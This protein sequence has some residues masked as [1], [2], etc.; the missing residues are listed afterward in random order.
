MIQ[1]LLIVGT[2]NAAWHLGHAC[3][4]AGITIQGVVARDAM[5]GRALAEALGGVPYFAMYN[6]LPDA[7]AYLL[8]V[9]DDAIEEVAKQLGDARQLM[10]HCSGSMRADVLNQKQNPYGVLWPMHSLQ[11]D[12]PDSLQHALIAVQGSDT[13]IQQQ[14]F[15]LASRISERAMLVEEHQRMAMHMCAVWVN[16]YTNH[17]LHI[18]FSLLRE[19]GVDHRLFMPMLRNHMAALESHTPDQIQTGPAKRGEMQT[20]ERHRQLLHNHPDLQQI[21]DTLAE[22]ILNTYLKR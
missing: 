4:A 11:K 12:A 17:M 13:D 19:H 22:H 8:A 3:L 10:I 20:L 2:G 7:D 6:N 5:K 18:G 14:I 16:N 9:R 1:R 15:E 21:Y